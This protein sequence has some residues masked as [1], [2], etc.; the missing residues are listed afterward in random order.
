MTFLLILIALVLVL[1]VLLGRLSD[2]VGIPVLLA[3]LAL[4][5][6]FGSDGLFKIPFENFDFA[7]QISTV[8]LIFIIFY[9]GFGT[10]WKAA[11]PVALPAVLLSTAGVVL[12]AL[13][14]GVFCH[15]VLRLSWL[16]SLLLGSVIS[17]T[18]AASVFSILRSKRLSLKYGTAS[19]LE[20]ESGS[21]DPFAYMMT[22]LLLRMMSGG[23][24]G[25]EVALLAF[26]Q[27]FFGL[28]CGA[29]LAWAAVRLFR[30]L[31]HDPAAVPLMTVAV[32]LLSYALPTALGGNGYLSAYLVG[33][34]LGNQKF[35]DKKAMVTFL[36]GVAS[37]MQ[38]ALFFLLGLLSSPSR[39]PAC[40][41]AALA[42]MLF[43]TLV[44]RP[45][46]TFL[47]LTPFRAPLRQQV[48]VSWAG[49][50]GA[51]SIVFAI[52]AVIDQA[53]T[54]GDLFHIVFCVV[55]LSIGLQ[56]TFLPWCA[57]RMDMID[58]QEDVLRTF[59]DYTAD[60]PVQFIRLRIHQDHPWNGVPLRQAVLPPDTRAA[61]ILRGDARI[62]PRGDTCL[63]AGDVLILSAMAY[64]DDRHLSL[65]ETILDR[66]H[67][68]CGK[69][70]SEIDWG[71]SLVILVRR[72]EEAL[73]PTGS[74]EL[75]PGD[76]LVMASDPG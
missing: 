65:S 20:L 55:L 71:G 22:F 72:G 27:I 70:L 26:R 9:G 38:I 66:K 6:V 62:L 60:T 64:Q 48:V 33:I 57:R 52:M 29:A 16:E 68:W 74:L 42:I 11:R 3:F 41:P 61:L 54:H 37:L 43:L 30:K 76:T 69:R 46:A 44:S 45:A 19:L 18:D 49:L 8:A 25:G 5:M 47:L 75:C 51:T 4:G 40:L 36:D 2:H 63:C 15:F 17:S 73:L 34:V 31:R 23:V 12:T 67:E 28:A 53:Q 35:S 14:T 1:G 21:N 58:E 32:A 10:N 50:R 59:T 56:G 7:S 24:T 39:L 13:F